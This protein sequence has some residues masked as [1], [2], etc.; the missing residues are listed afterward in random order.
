MVRVDL[1]CGHNGDFRM[2]RILFWGNSV[3]LSFGGD[4][5]CCLRTTTSDDVWLRPAIDFPPFA[6]L[7]GL[8]SGV[9]VAVVADKADIRMPQVIPQV[10]SAPDP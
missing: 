3:S 8:L 1:Y 4:P 9:F 5:R 6:M 7:L 2:H 10:G